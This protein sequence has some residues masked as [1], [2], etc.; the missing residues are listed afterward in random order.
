MKPPEAVDGQMRIFNGVKW[1]Y[2]PVP[3]TPALVEHRVEK[4]PEVRENPELLKLAVD[5]MRGD[6][7]M[8]VLAAAG[9][10]LEAFRSRLDESTGLIEGL[11]NEARGAFARDAE[12]SGKIDSM[13]MLI[14]AM[15]QR[16][17]NFVGS[18]TAL[19]DRIQTLEDK[20]RPLPVPEIGEK[21]VAA[22][23][24]K[25]FGFWS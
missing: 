22:V 18:V 20:Y 14:G 19:N 5:N 10:Q 9:S 1:E 13:I 6:L 7:E 16:L 2:R 15:N 25:K 12:L 3:K 21:V 11:R 23:E 17:D 8:R 4:V 24:K